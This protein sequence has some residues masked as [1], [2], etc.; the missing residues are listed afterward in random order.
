MKNIPIYLDYAAAT[1]IDQAAGNVHK[2]LEA[3]RAKAVH[4][5]GARPSEMVFTAGGT[6]ANNLA[7]H[8]VMR[9]FPEANI[10]VSAIEHESVI[11]PAARYNYSEATVQP[12]GRLNLEDLRSKVDNKTVLVS[13]MYAN[14]E[15]GTVQPIR[16]ISQ[17]LEEIRRERQVSGNNLPLYL[18]SDACQA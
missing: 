15:I 5:L 9:R 1:A 16:E 13:V 12:D 7:I 11:A 3:A 8:G 14:N 10:V 17:L 4:W 6:E 18:H 2:A